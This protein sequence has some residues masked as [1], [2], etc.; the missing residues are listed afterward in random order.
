MQAGG[1]R[2]GETEGKEI[3]KVKLTE[4]RQIEAGVWI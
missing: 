3:E 2:E 4:A 1:H